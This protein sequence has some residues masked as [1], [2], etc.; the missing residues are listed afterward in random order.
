[1]YDRYLNL[2]PVYI[3]TRHNGHVATEK[4]KTA[5]KKYGVSYDLMDVELKC[6]MKAMGRRFREEG[7]GLSLAS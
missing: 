1:M 4:V 6:L 3:Q 5:C 2:Y 7:S